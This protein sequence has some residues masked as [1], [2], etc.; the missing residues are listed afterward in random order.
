VRLNGGVDI[1]NELVLA[2]L[3]P[4]EKFIVFLLKIV[5]PPEP[6]FNDTPKFKTRWLW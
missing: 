4:F 3:A 1:H 2:L 5:S 6:D